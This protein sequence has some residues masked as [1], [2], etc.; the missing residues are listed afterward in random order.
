[1]DSKAVRWQ[2]SISSV[3]A[4]L[5][6]GHLVWPSIKLDAPSV[7]LIALCFLPWLGAI[8][9]S[10][11]LPGGT[12]VEYREGLLKATRKLE[13]V[14]LLQDGRIQT[15][16]PV[17]RGLIDRDSNLAL[18]GLRIDI[19]RKL[20]TLATLLHTTEPNGSLRQV[21]NL[22]G[23][24][25]LFTQIQTEAMHGIL[26]CLNTAVHGGKIPKDDAEEVMENGIRLLETLDKRITKQKLASS[27][28]L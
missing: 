21:V 19:E 23:S 27:A 17:Y 9:K 16:D 22:I 5:L 1:M 2:I 15:E 10:I 25:G 6:V 11:E 12:K 26:T 4:V 18:A 3:S 7:F 13:E 24:R 20:R 8:F 14:G 28:P